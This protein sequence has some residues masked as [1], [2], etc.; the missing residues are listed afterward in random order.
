M[1]HSRPSSSPSIPSSTPFPL[2]T[3][4]LRRTRQSIAA[5]AHVASSSPAGRA[6]R[7]GRRRPRDELEEEDVVPPSDDDEYEEW[8]DGRAAKKA[9]EDSVGALS[10]TPHVNRHRQL[11]QT[12]SLPT[13]PQ[14]K[15]PDKDST[16]AVR[17]TPSRPRVYINLFSPDRPPSPSEWGPS[18]PSSG[19]TTPTLRLN[20]AESDTFG[21]NPVNRPPTEPPAPVAMAEAWDGDDDELDL[22]PTRPKRPNINRG[23]PSL[24]DRIEELEAKSPAILASDNRLSP[25]V[26]ARYTKETA[27]E[28]GISPARFTGTFGRRSESPRVDALGVLRNGAG[29]TMIPAPFQNVMSQ[30]SVDDHQSLLG[31][32]K[33]I[34]LGKTPSTAARHSQSPRSAASPGRSRE[35]AVGMRALGEKTMESHSSRRLSPGR[36]DTLSEEPKKQAIAPVTPSPVEQDESQLTPL[37]PSQPKSQHSLPVHSAQVLDYDPPFQDCP[38]PSPVGSPLQERQVVPSYR[39]HTP[40][41]LQ[42]QSQVHSP[43]PILR[44]SSPEADLNTLL[45][46]I[47][48]RPMPA[49]VPTPDPTPA[50]ASAPVDAALQQFRT[51]RTFRTRTNVQ[52]HPYTKERQIYE[53]MLRKGGIRAKQDLQRAQAENR[54][55]EEQASRVDKDDALVSQ[56]SEPSV[57]ESDEAEDA[58]DNGT[59]ERIVI[60]PGASPSRPLRPG[61][62]PLPLV[63]ADLDEYLMTFGV[64]PD[65]DDMDETTSRKLQSIARQ[66]IRKAKD[67]EK[68]RRQEERLNRRFQK[69]LKE[70][71]LKES[72]EKR[73]L[74][75][76]REEEMRLKK[77][78]VRE[79]RSRRLQQ[80]LETKRIATEQ[81]R[82][83]RKEKRRREEE[84]DGDTERFLNGLRG[85]SVEGA[86]EDGDAD[87]E[88]ARRDEEFELF[89]EGLRG[90]DEAEVVSKTKRAKASKNS[91]NK[92]T[93]GGIKTYGHRDKRPTRIPSS[94]DFDDIAL[95]AGPLHVPR[96]HRSHSPYRSP[97]PPV[98]Y[99]SN[100]IDFDM[101][102]QGYDSDH[103]PDLPA[104]PPSYSPGPGFAE[105]FRQFSHISPPR[106]PALGGDSPVDDAKDDSEVEGSD[107]SDS[108]EVSHDD[109][110]RRIAGRMMP[111]RMLRQLEQEAA[112]KERE[113]QERKRRD[114]REREIREADGTL[115]VGP[116]RAVVRRQKGQEAFDDIAELFSQEHES[117]GDGQPSNRPTGDSGDEGRPILVYDSDSSQAYEDNAAEQPLARLHRGDFA[118]IVAGRSRV[119]AAAQKAGKRKADGRRSKAPERPAIGLVRQ[120]GDNNADRGDRRSKEPRQTRLDFPSVGEAE[121]RSRNKR[122]RR[123]QRPA[124]RLD[125][126]VIFAA[127]DFAF[128]SGND[129]PTPT[130]PHPTRVARATERVN[131]T[132]SNVSNTAAP[133]LDVG[134]GKAR[135]WAN[136]DRFSTDFGISPLPAGLFCD[137]ESIPGSGRLASLVTFLRRSGNQTGVMPGTVKEFGIE[138]AADMSPAAV[139]EVIDIV[140]DATHRQ[141]LALA[142]RST[143][144]EVPLGPLIFL[145]SYVSAH[146]QDSELVSLRES[147][148]RCVE[149]MLAK[150]D[151]VDIAQ[152]SNNQLA[153]GSLLNT[154]WALFELVCRACAGTA[155][156]TVNATLVQECTFALLRQLLLNGFDLTI[157]PLKA[158]MAGESDSPEIKDATIT[159]WISILHSTS[160]WDSCAQ[161]SQDTLFLGAFNRAIDIVFPLDRTGPIAAERIWYLVFGLCALSQFNEKGEINETFNAVPRWT[162]VKRAV[163]LIKVVF[164]EDAEK[165]AH[166]QTLRGRD[167][168]IKAMMAR[169]VKLSAVWK[170]YF[171]RDSFSLVNRDLG[172][173]FKDRQ[174]RNLPT[175]PP[176]DYPEFITHYDMSLS[177]SEDTRHETAFDL[178][179]RLVC[180]AASDIIS[181]AESL[182]E[183]QRAEKD[184]QRLAM[185]TIPISSVKFNRILPPGPRELAQLTNRYSTMIAACYFSPS[186]LRY[187][188]ANSKNW[189]PFAQADYESREVCIRGLMY[190]AVACR[191][192]DQPLDPVVERLAE[193]LQILQ[194]ELEGHAKGILPPQAAK[195]PEIKNTMVLIVVCFREMIKHHSFDVEE[196]SKPVYPDPSLLHESWTLRIFDLDLA[197]DLKCGFEV[198]STIQAF[199]DARAKVLPD[200]VRR[201]RAAKES[202]Q[203]QDS[204]D[205]FGS[206][207]I[208][209]TAADVLA[210]GGEEAE[211]D[212]NEESDR[213]FVEII[214][215]VISP[216]IYQLLSDMLPFVVDGEIDKHWPEERQLFIGKLTK[217]WSD[218][219]AVLVVEHVKLDWNT[220]ISSHGRQSWTRLG[221]EQGR[222]QVG[223]HFMLNVL[224]LDPSSFTEH[225]DDFVA[226]LYQ[227][228]GT[229]KLTIEH[230]YAG[231]ILN[232]ARASE[233]LLLI[234]VCTNNT[235][236]KNPDR[237]E[238]MENRGQILQTLFMTC[239]NLL[240]SSHTPAST[241]AFIYR[242]INT[243]VSSLVSYDK[244]INDNKVLHKESYRA[245]LDTTLSDL[246]RCAGTYFHP[247]SVPG[248][249]YFPKP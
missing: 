87:S 196:Q 160:A 213:K 220:F 187:L 20:L 233:H 72:R 75:R 121:A 248:L 190:L 211:P 51:A 83:E 131:P 57:S 65:V 89:M 96:P 246:Q 189:S 243:F 12:K 145:S 143:S 84:I 197:N 32:Q 215:N 88:D 24:P 132:T 232:L 63:D 175:E 93:P 135:S 146:E 184:V 161:S 69:T 15:K 235:L 149:E 1:P 165:R 36:D 188:L 173:I 177:A 7:S 155:E 116:G 62:A 179:L 5:D 150:L 170:W 171:E 122:K 26:S 214:E 34:S 133:S 117:D 18:S 23:R 81:K 27:E 73:R 226:L 112:Q 141:L 194:E 154:Q 102:A 224:E 21:R 231:T 56:G 130:S 137:P 139:Q 201:R 230:K 234:D 210:L 124:I 60:G 242:C 38:S 182:A 25:E 19:E 241:K 200:S 105:T 191:H 54:R 192:H 111:A 104:L 95:E 240:A 28:E 144:T 219:A 206:M 109:P 42:S 169:C 66:R 151:G 180:V 163:S 162:L 183:A 64:V 103:G 92:R 80:E 91:T 227:S 49:R 108:E 48:A 2:A 153:K 156:S 247:M 4:R 10:P 138:L 9:R 50:P 30:T 82:K 168:Y 22:L 186:L 106:R 147:L 98:S 16:Q 185:S 39:V 140:F 217:C 41:L 120:K 70:L 55:R 152:S 97:S 208:D 118:G 136:F 94:S 127:D 178:Y 199:L 193:I 164:D 239:S 107:G 204:F 225:G 221:D 52:L 249:K 157:R 47:A 115:S 33:D 53:A 67:D 218:C 3:Q 237:T 45:G 244:S 17:V 110:R 29:E 86:G 78:Q 114:L 101:D 11:A 77:Q 35:D 142:N 59:G 99:R 159:L 40:D 31:N 238:F 236:D 195:K 212:P 202:V 113:K 125:D 13:C 71:S 128:D 228:I 126:D 8:R 176:V 174:Y 167:R 223:L 44:G 123:N 79:E 14:P 68:K 76:L 245:F 85:D 222:V 100:Q 90:G 207:G 229:D 148:L 216:K 198:I 134:I 43:P 166:P 181:G 61:R 46:E 203:Q 172:N 58:I 119:K 74:E 6:T 129:D 205:E 37:T 158:I 209:F